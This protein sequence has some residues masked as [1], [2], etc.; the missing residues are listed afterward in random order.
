MKVP[1]ELPVYHGDSRMGV[2]PCMQ[3]ACKQALQKYH[4]NPDII[5]VMLEKKDG[6]TYKD[7]KRASDSQL[8]IPSQCV[9]YSNALKKQL[10]RKRPQYCANI[11]LKVNTKVGGNNC[12]IVGRAELHFPVLGNDRFII[13]GADVTHPAT[14]QTTEPSVA[15]VVASVD[16]YATKYAARFIVQPSK[17]EII[18]LKDVAQELLMEYRQAMNCIP[19]KIIF[20]RDGVSEG[21][22]SQVLDKECKQ[23]RE[24]CRA[25]AGP[26]SAYDPKITFIVVQKRHHTRLFP[27]PNEGDKNGNVLPGTVVDS[28]I[29]HPFG[30]DFFLNSHAGIQ[31]TNKPAHYHVLLDENN[32]GAD[33]MQMMTFWLCF[34]YCRC[35]RSVSYCPP[36]Y[37]AHLAAFRGKL[38]VNWSDSSSESGSEDVSE[39]LRTH[40]ALK[41]KMYFV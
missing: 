33:G 39:T 37:Y 21:Q 31:G 1:D 15:G 11:A 36:A 7:V 22:F 20:Y 35:T 30:F 10:D 27:K 41:R 25:V 23:L 14:R 8:G 3:E 17:E 32:F 9:L 16:A 28:G 19:E 13:F 6:S 40:A 38:M 5:F 2:L 24:A 12:K 29:A 18:D 34:L 4:R 26:S